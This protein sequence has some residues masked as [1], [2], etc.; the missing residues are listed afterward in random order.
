MN[1]DV[2]KLTHSKSVMSEIG[3]I[4]AKAIEAKARTIQSGSLA[5]ILFASN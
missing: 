3:T 5:S 4:E 2:C 1:V